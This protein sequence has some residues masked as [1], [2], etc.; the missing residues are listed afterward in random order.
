[1]AA[2]GPMRVSCGRADARTS[3]PRGERAAYDEATM[4]QH[5]WR[6]GVLTLLIASV[7]LGAAPADAAPADGK[8]KY[9]WERPPGPIAGVWRVTCADSAG[10][11][12]HVVVD[13]K[14]ASGVIK[15]VGAARRFGYR[16]GEQIFKNLK[17]NYEGRWS[18]HHKWRDVSGTVRWDPIFFEASAMRLDALMTTDNCFRRMP[19][20]K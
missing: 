6:A 12:V 7:L 19:R 13:S 1:M 11:T 8:K 10:M 2:L 17:P 3:S 20:V 5:R 15:H 4:S 9:P 18:G 16:S 14:R